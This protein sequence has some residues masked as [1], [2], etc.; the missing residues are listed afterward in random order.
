MPVIER[1]AYLLL[2][3]GLLWV[4]YRWLGRRWRSAR[5]A[6]LP[7]LERLA[8]G[9]VGI[10]YFTTPGCAP[11]RIVQQPALRT[12]QAE[13][14][15]SLQ[16]VQVD[17]LERPGLADYWGVL[18]V[19]TTFLID[20]DGRVRGVNHGVAQAERLRAQIRRLEDLPSGTATRPRLAT[21]PRGRAPE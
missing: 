16:V 7:G 18:S 2:I 10:L 12:L 9:K 11:C 4:A 21:D 20:R 15:E 13:M 8:R 5:A 14:G 3:G 19:P 1:L 17:A 6:D